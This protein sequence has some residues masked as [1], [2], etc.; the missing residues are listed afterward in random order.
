VRA[1]AL[2]VRDQL[3]WTEI[4]ADPAV[5]NARAIRAFEKAGLV[6]TRDAPD[7]PDGPSVIMTF[8]RAANEAPGHQPGGREW[9]SVDPG[10]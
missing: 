8:R 1:L 4:T 5:G 6:R 9:S 7:H 10:D 2:H 3:G